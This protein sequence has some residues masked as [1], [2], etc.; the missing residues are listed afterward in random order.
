MMR[1]SQTSNNSIKCPVLIVGGG[2]VGMAQALALA[3]LAETGA[4]NI[5]L[6]DKVVFTRNDAARDLRSFAITA[7]SRRML[8]RL[9]VWDKVA[10]YA[11]P[12]SKMLISDGELDQMVRPPLLELPTEDSSEDG[13]EAAAIVESH[14]LLAVLKARV[15]QD[16][17]ISVIAPDRVTGVERNGGIVNVT[18]EKN[19]SL[20]TRLVV[21]ADGAKSSI[22]RMAGIKT[23]D[24]DYGQTGI[25][26]TIALD[27]PH[28]GRAIQHFLPAGP[29]AMLPL[30]GNSEYAHRGSLV[31]SEERREARRLM[32]LDEAGFLE[33]L[34]LRLGHQFGEA[35]MISGPQAF[36]LG[37][38]L[39]RDFVAP[40]IVVIGDA[41]HRLH[42]L[43][44]QG[45]NL[46]F[47]DVAALGDTLIEAQRV[48]EDFASL[49][50]LERYQTWRRFDVVS[51]AMAMDGINRIFSN[52]ISGLK[53]LRDVGLG[54]VDRFLPLKNLLTR[55]AAGET[56]RVPALMRVGDV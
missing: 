53:Q 47:K 22:R 15:K 24:W 46:G 31:W 51:N 33:A 49:T 8:A 10:P 30:V 39:A 18:L 48:G 3:A 40:G 11:Q 23:T 34:Q 21:A 20:S 32:D 9:G 44:G 43:A 7:A 13:K 50:V 29:F 5:V 55:E 45:A 35:R 2:L 37:M 19:G 38:T 28:K 52:R 17:R 6:V 36:P 26:A 12:V 56:G 54:L 14:Y 42:P 41:A 16:K 4:G 27:R 1:K 25:V